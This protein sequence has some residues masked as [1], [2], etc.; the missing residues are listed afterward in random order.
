MKRKVWND[1]ARFAHHAGG[2]PAVSAGLL[3]LALAAMLLCGCRTYLGYDNVVVTE[4][5]AERQ[6]LSTQPVGMEAALDIRGTT[7][8]LTFYDRQLD[9]WENQE[10]TRE[11]GRSLFFQESKF[12][13][14]LRLLSLPVSLPV[15]IVLDC[16][17]LSQK[18]DYRYREHEP[19]ALTRLAYA[20]P[21][22]WLL[23]PFIRP[24]YA[25]DVRDERVV[26]EFQPYDSPK[27]LAQAIQPVQQPR[28]TLH[29]ADRDLRLVWQDG[30]GATPPSRIIPIRDGAV[31]FDLRELGLESVRPPRL[32]SFRLEF[33]PSGK[34]MVL[35]MPSLLTPEIL[36]DWNEMA[37]PGYDFPFRFQALIR[38]KPF[39][40]PDDFQ[41]LFQEIKLGTETTLQTFAEGEYLLLPFE[42]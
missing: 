24:P 14:F 19:D 12:N 26:T 15:A 20:P 17:A 36:R 11:T 2:T 40:S 3:T 23:F 16:Q 41:R 42:R 34:T 1:P 39:I 18:P 6:H 35:S 22:S 13:P 10:E 33:M 4:T 8:Q 32:L 31:Q 28:W 30:P 25:G 7:C 27:R 38:L 9:S 5:T 29:T 37:Y 21:V